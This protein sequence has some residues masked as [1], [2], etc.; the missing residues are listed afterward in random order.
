MRENDSQM[1]PN[2][3][4][5]G[6]HPGFS[7]LKSQKN[8]FRAKLRPQLNKAKS[9]HADYHGILQLDGGKKALVFLWVHQDG[10]L[11]LRVELLPTLSELSE[12]RRT[13]EAL[14]NENIPSP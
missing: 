5:L 9:E 2:T 11:G 14:T 10:S 7:K 8:V 12:K 1:K 6:Q 4:P 13:S 3:L